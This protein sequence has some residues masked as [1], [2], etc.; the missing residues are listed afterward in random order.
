M[1]PPGSQVTLNQRRFMTKV[2]ARDRL[3]SCLYKEPSVHPD[4]DLG[5][6]AEGEAPG[7][8][9]AILHGVHLARACGVDL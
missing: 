8:G 4:V 7:G 1:K 5:A 2:I 6:G 3:S 9:G